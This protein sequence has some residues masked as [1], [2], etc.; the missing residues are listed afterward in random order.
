MLFR[1]LESEG[2][3]PVLTLAAVILTYGAAAALGGSGFLAVY[4]AGIVVGRGEFIQKRTL[5]RFHDGIAWLAQITLFVALGLLVFPSHLLSVTWGGLA[6]AAFVMF[7]GRPASVFLSLA[8]ARVSRRQKLLVSWV[9]LRGA[10]PIMLA[11]F[12]LLAGLPDAELYFNLVFFVVLTAVAIQGATIARVARALR[13][14]APLSPRREYPLE[15]V[16]TRKSRSEMVEV[17]IGPK[18]KAA[19]KPIVDLHLPRTALVV[20]IARKD[21]F[22][23]PRGGTVVR[24]G[25]VLLV[26]TDKAEIETV[27]SLLDG[28]PP[29]AV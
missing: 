24:P 15:F 5:M 18:S 26:L 4:L 19:G 22:I 10:A 25:D 12:P 14:E 3:Y 16:P 29:V 2:L 8:A 9:G 23:A 13:L 11:T 17:A 27:Q 6:L 21:D 20:L 1:S 7:V 28:A